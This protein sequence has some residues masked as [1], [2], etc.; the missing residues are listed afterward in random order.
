MDT[1]GDIVFPEIIKTEL[2]KEDKVVAKSECFVCPSC[3][4]LFA[5]EDNFTEHIQQHYLSP[6]LLNHSN[7]EHCSSTV[8]VQKVAHK[9]PDC[10]YTTGRAHNL[11][12]HRRV[13]TREKPY[14]CSHC[15]F[16]T[17]RKSTLA[18]HQRNHDGGGQRT[19]RCSLCSFKTRN[20]SQLISHQQVHEQSS[21]PTPQAILATPPVST[22]GGKTYTGLITYRCSLC[23]F[24]TRQNS[25]LVEHQR[26]HQETLS[27]P[28][29]SLIS[30][31]APSAQFSVCAPST[32][33]SV[34]A[35]ST[36]FSVCTPRTQFS[37]CAP[38][39]QF[40]VCAPS[41]QFSV[42]AP[43]TQFSVS[44]PSTQ[45]S[46]SAPSTQFS[47]SSPSTQ[48]TVEKDTPR[49]DST[50]NPIFVRPVLFVKPLISSSAVPTTWGSSS[51][52][53]HLSDMK[54][55]EDSPNVPLCEAVSSPSGS[56]FSSS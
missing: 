33:F 39:A 21:L 30:P 25:Q 38:S 10:V 55:A 17:A 54:L 26:I 40:S 27:R 52:T 6:P 35:P 5:N 11:N 36:Q 20:N 44:A 42:C 18:S 12:V 51:R 46:V 48:M 41:T 22:I 50:E 53:Y 47:V 8:P 3:G 34:C 49:K 4:V 43:S 1:E 19:Y 24:K 2:K 56:V 13:H 31:S 14:K 9:C 16:S 23:S 29:P 45:F 32:Q 15:S 37:V 28:L 7:N